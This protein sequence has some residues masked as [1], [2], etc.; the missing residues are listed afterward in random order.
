MALEVNEITRSDLNKATRQITA[1]I[2]ER[3]KLS[4]RVSSL[5]NLIQCTEREKM[6]NFGTRLISTRLHTENFPGWE[7][8]DW[9]T[10]K[11]P[12]KIKSPFPP[13]FLEP[14]KIR[15]LAKNHYNQEKK[16][17]D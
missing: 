4:K 7:R 12:G 17:T 6:E 10:F 9:S 5:K 14:G 11:P 15:S 8:I 3:D 13:Y 16:G 2:L 1:L